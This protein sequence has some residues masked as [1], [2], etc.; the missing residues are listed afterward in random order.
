MTTFY[1]AVAVLVIVDL[2]QSSYQRKLNRERE[3]LSRY[4]PEA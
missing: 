4:R 3:E 1:F 2:L